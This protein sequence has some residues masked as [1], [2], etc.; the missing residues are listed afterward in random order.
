MSARGWRISREIFHGDEIGIF[1]RWRDRLETG[2]HISIHTIH[3]H[4]VPPLDQKCLCYAI[5]RVKRSE[6]S[7][8]QQTPHKYFRTEH[9][10]RPSASSSQPVFLPGSWQIEDT[11]PKHPRRYAWIT[12]QCVIQPVRPAACKSGGVL[13]DR[14]PPWV[15]RR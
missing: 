12:I 6:D 15:H 11:A 1:E 5:R 9:H 7:R 13:P 3:S 4:P 2:R 10:E 8:V 14:V